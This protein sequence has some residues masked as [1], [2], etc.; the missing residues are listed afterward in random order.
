M[1][2]YTYKKESTGEYKDVYQGMNDKHEYRGE[3]G[4]EDDWKRV[5]YVPNASIDTQIDPHSS[6]QFTERTGN[7]KGTVGDLLDYSKE[8]SAKRAESNGGVDPVK[9]KYYE[10]YSKQRNGA[11]HFDQMKSFES[12]NIKVEY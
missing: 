9:Q 8:M 5:F 12:K 6:K 2:F 7:K 10:N 11:K 3:N 1:P 4:D